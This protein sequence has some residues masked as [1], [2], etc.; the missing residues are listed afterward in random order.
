MSIARPRAGSAQAARVALR[1]EWGIGDDEVALGVV[2]RLVADKGVRE[3]LAA[4]RLLRASTPR[5]RVVLVGPVDLAKADAI[6]ADELAAAEADGVVVAGRRD[7]MPEV[8]AAFDVFVTAS[9]R[10]GVPR[11]AM[12]AALR[13]GLPTVATDVRGEPSGGRRRGHRGPGTR[14]RSGRSR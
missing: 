7:D 12:E 5:A 9:W 3:V 6:T 2:A 4:A 13:P 1:A 10:E 14:P 11:A 8:Y